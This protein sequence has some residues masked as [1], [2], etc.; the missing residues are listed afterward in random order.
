MTC[1]AGWT[2]VSDRL[3]TNLTNDTNKSAATLP[4]G[5]IPVFAPAEDRDP[6]A[7]ILP[8]DLAHMGPGQALRAWT[9]WRRRYAVRDDTDLL[10]RDVRDVRGSSFLSV[11]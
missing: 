5:V 9:A 3:T 6:E 2:E 1:R 7:P 11:L 8:E 4:L 10:V